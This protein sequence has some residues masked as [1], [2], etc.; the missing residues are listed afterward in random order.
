MATYGI[1]LGT[2]NTCIAYVDH[3]GRPVV[4]QSAQ[5]QDTTPSVVYF[6]SPDHVVVGEQAKGS[7]KLNPDLV[8]ERIKRQMGHDVRYSFHGQEHTPESIS[9][10]ILREVT[11]AAEEQTRE[12][13]RDVVITVPA[14]FGVLEREATRKAGIIAGLNVLDVLAEPV[15]AAVSYHAVG[16][17]AGTR[18]IFVFDLGGGTFDTT[19]MRLDGNDV[20]VI[21][22]DGD[23]MLGGADWD[24]KVSSFLL[25]GF[26]EQFPQ[27]DPAGDVQ[28][29]QDLSTSAEQLKKALSTVLT[30]NHHVRF[31]GSVAQLQLTRDHL[32]EITSEFLEQT[33]AITERTLATARERGVDKYDDV[34][35]VGGMTLAP[36]VAR[37]LSERFGLEGR[38]QDPHLAV[39][40]G[41]ALYALTR[42]LKVG[43]AAG[44]E[45]GE[46]VTE[47]DL[48][49]QE[50]ETGIPREVLQGIAS[51]HVATVV[52]RAFG[53]KVTDSS[54]PLFTIDKSRARQYIEHLLTAN[55]PLPADAGPTTFATIEDNQRQVRIE[56]WEQAGPVASEELGHNT[57]IGQG[58]LTDL[59]PKPAGAPFEVTFHLTET[60]A[61][62]V[63]AT[64]AHSEREVRFQIQIGGLGEAGVH[65]ATEAVSRYEVSG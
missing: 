27:L 24:D 51:I 62:Q 42:K 57:Q 23:K 2:T 33:A 48:D 20:Q 40:R 45:A 37:M 14:Y 56:V 49:Q 38:R 43:S 31:D 18:H 53:I 41:A 6:E 61:L 54:D 29:M 13:V 1:D 35:L 55:T 28:F 32:E 36:A 11:R 60:G 25:R 3:T 65:E 63:H 7:A 46:T 47:A 19:V 59:P 39:A 17:Q 8:V 9:A 10:L 64:E 52:P 44:E 12:V 15:A 34:L 21:C 50:R 16:G 26:S 58:L 4:V 5:G 30:R 22:T